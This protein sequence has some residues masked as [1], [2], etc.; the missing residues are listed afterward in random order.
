MRPSIT[1]VVA[2]AIGMVAWHDSASAQ[3]VGV[4][5]G[6]PAYDPY[7]GYPDDFYYGPRVYGFTGRTYAPGDVEFGFV[8]PGRRCPYAHYWN[9]RRCAHFTEPSAPP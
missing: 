4:Y 3:G 7:Y 2:A 1:L 8:T 5:V 9:G 6:P